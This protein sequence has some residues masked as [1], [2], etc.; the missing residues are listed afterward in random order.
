MPLLLI[1][2]VSREMSCLISLLPSSLPLYP[3]MCSLPLLLSPFFYLLE[4]VDLLI[5]LLS[6]YLLI[7]S[8]S[9][10]PISV[11][12]PIVTRS[13]SLYSRRPRAHV[14]PPHDE[15]RSTPTPATNLTNEVPFMPLTIMP[16][17]ALVLQ[18]AMSPVPIRKQPLYLS[19]KLL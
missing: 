6:L 12:S 9:P 19:D 16:Q 18:V 4:S 2:F 1:G 14:E 5:C 7:H 10:T 17:P 11:I 13:S 3:Q 15:T 8:S